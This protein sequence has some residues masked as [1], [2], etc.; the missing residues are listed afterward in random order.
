MGSGPTTATGGGGT[1]P[2][3]DARSELPGVPG[4]TVLAEL[5]RG[6]ATVVYRVRHD[7]ADWAMKVCTGSSASNGAE[8]V[9]F[10][11]EAALLALAN[12][13]AL[14]SVHEVGLSDG[15]PY[16]VMDF[17]EGRELARTLSR[18]PLDD[19]A[20]R[21]LAVEVTVRVGIAHRTSAD[22]TPP[23]RFSAAPM[24]RST[25]PST[26]VETGW[27][28]PARRQHVPRMRSVYAPPRWEVTATGQGSSCGPVLG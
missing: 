11:R 16:L 19:V 23:G 18:G 9:T 22:T 17:I 10:R 12:H 24:R 15:R 7:G 5:G 27:L 26:A 1:R 13:P 20:V 2:C 28:S 8:L 3:A 4:F 14:P 6:A 21:R 25:R